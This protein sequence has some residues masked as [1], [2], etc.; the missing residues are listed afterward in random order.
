[1]LLELDESLVSVSILSKNHLCI[2]NFLIVV[3]QAQRVGKQIVWVSIH[4][5]GEL[6]TWLLITLWIK[7]VKNS[8]VFEHERYRNNLSLEQIVNCIRIYIFSVHALQGIQRVR[9]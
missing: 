2:D 8:V 6:T 7:S 5:I 3:N 4:N 9:Q 1:M